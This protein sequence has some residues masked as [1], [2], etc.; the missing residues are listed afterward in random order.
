MKAFGK[1]YEI[2][3]DDVAL[4]EDYN[5]LNAIDDGLIGHEEIFA[6]MG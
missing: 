3:K 6:T 4:E 5:G 1:D 2:S